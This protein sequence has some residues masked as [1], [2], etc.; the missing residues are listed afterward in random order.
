M[1]DSQEVIEAHQNRHRAIIYTIDVSSKYSEHAAKIINGFRRS[2]YTRDVQFHVGNVSVWLDQQMDSRDQTPFLSHVILDLPSS[3]THVE[4][5][6]SA[7]H[8]NGKLVLFNPSIT[9]IISAIELVKVRRL[10]LQLERVVEVGL[11]MTGGRIWD[12]RRTKPRALT[13]E[14]D[15]GMTSATD[16]DDDGIFD[17]NEGWKTVCK[18]KIGDRISAGGFV[19]LWSKNKTRNDHP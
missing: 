7:L 3:Y 14:V 13:R 16:A 9:Q 12:V 19:A 2:M 18:P 17:N 10:P 15:E 1:D 6:V 5:A 11:A 8:V 4:K